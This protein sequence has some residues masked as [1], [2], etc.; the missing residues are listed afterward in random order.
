MARKAVKTITISGISG[1]VVSATVYKGESVELDKIA[2]FGDAHFTSVPRSVK[3]YGEFRFT[4]LDEGNASGL[5][6]LVGT[7]VNVSVSTQYSD[8]DSGPA[9]STV[10]HRSASGAG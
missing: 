5:T 8:G 7:V 3:S 2:A 10:S 1:P 6:A 4:I 9:T